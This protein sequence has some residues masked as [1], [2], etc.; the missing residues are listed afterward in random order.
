[1]SNVNTVTVS[2]NLTRDPE[3]KW[4]S[5]NGEAA[6][7]N[8]GIAVNRRVRDENAEGG[9]AEDVDFF[10]IDV[11]GKFALLV[12]KKLRKA[13]F[14]AVSGRLDYQAWETSEGEKRSK[15]VID[16]REIDSEGFFRS[17]EEDR[18]I[19]G[20]EAAPA[21]AKPPTATPKSDDIPF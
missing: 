21:A 10:D 17:R 18:A 16:A 4:L 19:G 5:D 15:V 9:Y 3:V 20:G 14:A 13:D 8:L 6:I 11:K 1:M 2:G 12:A 7:V